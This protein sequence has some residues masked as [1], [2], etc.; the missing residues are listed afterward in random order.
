MP[1]S[2]GRRL[3][4][5][6][7]LVPEA[8][9]EYLRPD[10]PT[11]E[12]LRAARSEVERRGVT[13]AAH[14]LE[15]ILAERD[16]GGLAESAVSELQ[17]VSPAGWL[18]L[19]LV[20]RRSWWSFPGWW[21]DAVEHAAS[22]ESVSSTVVASFHP[23]GR[24][25]EAA[26][27]LLAEMEHV[28]TYPA[29]ALR[30]ADWV[31]QVRDRAR[32]V[33]QRRI[34]A[35]LLATAQHAGPVALIAAR[36]QR[37]SWLAEEIEQRIRTAPIDV[38]RTLAGAVD[39]LVRRGALK[40]AVD[41]Q[42]LSLDELVTFSQSE[43]DLPGRV[44]CGLAAVELAQR[45]DR[46]R[47]VAPLLQNPASRVRQAALLAF[48]AIGESAVVDAAL[49]DW[50]PSVR[51]LAQRLARARGADPADTY[52]R[53]AA[54]DPAPIWA[55]AGLGE[56]GNAADVPR[57]ERSLS[58]ERPRARAEALRALRRLGTTSPPAL[59]PF[60]AD[61]SAAVTKQAAA[62]LR[63][64]AT[65]L[66][67]DQL[68]PLLFSNAPDHVRS[69]VYRLLRA[70]SPWIRLLV[71]LRLLSDQ[72]PLRQ[73]AH[74]DIGGWL[75]NEAARAYS[76][77]PDALAAE[78]RRLIDDRAPTLGRSVADSLRFHTGSSRPSSN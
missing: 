39:P 24:V 60:L 38:I 61:P 42:R 69:A 74:A 11:Q 1:E 12:D 56:V 78:I 43:R 76:K 19:D 20:A 77:P 5:R 59:L 75:A 27:A 21:R 65:A 23:N 47:S 32:V 63:P 49:A 4:R 73:R 40:A 17:G 34:D 8:R 58:D 10:P 51:G 22:K 55:I 9:R 14:F 66:D 37:G 67:V 46:V 72:D 29:L 15:L 52:R 64:V 13:G 16:A 71:N 25:R 62:A 36:R 7:G 30:T 33:M 26:T 70:H 6:V 35:D 54:G 68:M 3:L 57:V 50:T 2:L 28:T 48:D 31:E 44:L 45:E 41:A 53:A 18:T